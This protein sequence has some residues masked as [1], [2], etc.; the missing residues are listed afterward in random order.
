M[1]HAASLAAQSRPGK[2]TVPGAATGRQ[3]PP[4]DVRIEP[5]TPL[6]RATDR[7]SGKRH[8]APP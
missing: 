8:G 2:G 5:A 4:A 3:V 7:D 1:L 6:R